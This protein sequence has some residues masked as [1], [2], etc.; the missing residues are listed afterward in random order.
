MAR[1]WP[2]EIIIAYG[3][4]IQLCLNQLSSTSGTV[5][6]ASLS[7]LSKQLA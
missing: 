7:V 5:Y 3:L 4:Q 2:H 6:K 1:V